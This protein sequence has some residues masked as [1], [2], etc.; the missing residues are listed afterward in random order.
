[1][2][3]SQRNRG[4]VFEKVGPFPLKITG[5]GFHNEYEVSVEDGIVEDEIIVLKQISRPSLGDI[6]YKM[7]EAA[8]QSRIAY[9]MIENYRNKA[10]AEVHPQSKRV[11]AVSKRTNRK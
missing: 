3:P 4:T 8:N 1:M 10:S 7:Y 9:S 5:C 6:V 2:N 11:Q